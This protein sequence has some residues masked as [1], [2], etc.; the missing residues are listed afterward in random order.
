MGASSLQQE[1]G[2]GNCNKISSIKIYWPSSKILQEFKNVTVNNFYH[3][4][5][6]EEELLLINRKKIVLARK[7]NINRE[8]H[9]DHLHHH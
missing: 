3:V 2:L 5:E 9:I 4:K 8:K 1:I 7:S 6:D